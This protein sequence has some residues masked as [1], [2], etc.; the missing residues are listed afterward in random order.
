MRLEAVAA[1]L[2]HKNLEMTMVYA[3]IADDTVAEEYFDVTDLVDQLYTETRISPPTDRRSM[4]FDI[5]TPTPIE[6]SRAEALV[7]FDWISRHE[8]A[9]TP[10]TTPNRS[11]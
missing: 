8:D 7:I 4:N 5:V 11:P 9:G 3:R 10:A 2:G 1:L 6:L